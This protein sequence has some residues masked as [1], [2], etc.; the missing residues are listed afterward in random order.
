MSKKRSLVLTA[1]N[2][3]NHPTSE[4][5]IQQNIA[6]CVR[7]RTQ[8]ATVQRRVRFTEVFALGQARD[9]SACSGVTKPAESQPTV[10][11]LLG[12][13]RSANLAI[14]VPAEGDVGPEPIRR[15]A[16]AGFQ[17]TRSSGGFFHPSP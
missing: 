3:S 8:P 12:R 14:G 1:S 17:A 13:A 6:E 5:I 16:E 4:L 11:R 7:R 10:E 9:H 15:A 2:P